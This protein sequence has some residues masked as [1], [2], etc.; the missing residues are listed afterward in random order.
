MSIMGSRLL[1]PVF[2]AS[3]LNGQA[4]EPPEVEFN[5][6]VACI[7]ETLYAT[8]S[9][10]DY[11]RGL[12]WSVDNASLEFGFYVEFSGWSL[13]ISFNGRFYRNPDS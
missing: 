5:H 2:M 12:S 4:S 10:S 8:C 9:I 6:S 1:I 3:I 13:L 7:G 11:V